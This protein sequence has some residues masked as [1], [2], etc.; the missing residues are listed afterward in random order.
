MEKL[1]R[2]ALATKRLGERIPTIR[3]LMRQHRVSMATVTRALSHLKQDGLIAP[4]VGSGTYI[5]HSKPSLKAP[6]R[7]V[8][9]VIPR[10]DDYFFG[11]IIRS[12]D[13]SLARKGC[14]LVVKPL[15]G[16]LETLTR[17]GEQLRMIG[18]KGL[19]YVPVGRPTER[20]YVKW[21]ESFLAHFSAKD[22]AV[23]VL[24]Q[25]LPH[26]RFPCVRSDHAMGARMVAEHL[27]RLGHRRMVYVDCP[28]TSSSNL[29]WQAFRQYLE[30]HGCIGTRLANRRAGGSLE[31]SRSVAADIC[32]RKAPVTA[33]FA[34]NDV[35]ASK[36]LCAFQRKGI[37]VPDDIS[38]VGFDDIEYSRYSEPQLTT[39]SQPLGE[40]GRRTA[41]LILLQLQKPG[42]IP[43][44]VVLP[45]ELIKRSSTGISL[46]NPD[47]LI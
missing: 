14:H 29:R 2:K 43:P 1:L 4:R 19:V 11:R 9:V 46:T 3:D 35:V 45:V 30:E 47:P 17:F 24:D 6:S 15:H 36:L 32:R 26:I 40:I 39:V 37:R 31:A 25:A 22:W 28:Y 41:E 21:N 10:L 16:H 13:R 38:L 34:V 18:A 20:D 33:V 12:L 44:S 42:A 5:L 23:V 27:V 8:G 7:L